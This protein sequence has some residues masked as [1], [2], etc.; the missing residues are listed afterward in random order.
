MNGIN[1]IIA[2]LGMDIAA[3][4]ASLTVELILA[5]AAISMLISLSLRRRDELERLVLY[6]TTEL[7]K[8][9]QSYRNQFA[10][11]SAVML[12]IDPNHR[13]IFPLPH[14]ILAHVKPIRQCNR[15]LCL[16]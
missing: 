13:N 2:V 7:R 11:N 6:R 8:S 14:Q 15:V 16:I 9:E 12:M 10:Y 4:A 5:L 3:H 1:S